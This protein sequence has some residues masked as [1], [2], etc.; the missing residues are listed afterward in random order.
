MVT[1]L[2]SMRA[3]TT[4]MKLLLIGSVSAL[5]GLAIHNFADPFGGHMSIAMLWLH[6]AFLVAICR[7]VHAEATP[8]LPA[9]LRAPPISRLQTA[10]ESGM[11]SAL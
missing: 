11:R 8:V 1:A 3:A 6:A 5:F 10:A 9:R 2:R 7:R 4:E